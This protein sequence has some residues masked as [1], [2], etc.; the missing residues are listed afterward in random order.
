MAFPQIQSTSEGGTNNSTTPDF[1]YPTGIVAGD[2]IVLAVTTDNSGAAPSTP[3]S[4]WTIQ[5]NDSDSAGLP[6][7]I[8]TYTASGGESGTFN[9][10]T[11]GTGREHGYVCLRIDGWAGT[12]ATDIDFSSVTTGTTT[13]VST[14]DVTAGWGADDNLFVSFASVSNT[15][16]P[17]TTYPTNFPDNQ[18][19]GSN[20]FFGSVGVASDEQ[21][22]ATYGSGQ[23]WTFSNAGS[24]TASATMVVKPAAAPASGTTQSKLSLGLNLGLL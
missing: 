12:E 22:G 1:T 5:I 9:A 17:S 21:T 3:A 11:S 8:L 10:F 16:A 13:T 14:A 6:F 2:L 24:G 20:V 7:A 19:T 23:S 18:V 4:G 15:D